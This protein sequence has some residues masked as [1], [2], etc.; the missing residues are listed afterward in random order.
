MLRIAIAILALIV[1]VNLGTVADG[2]NKDLSGGFLASFLTLLAGANRRA[3]LALGG[4]AD[5]VRHGWAL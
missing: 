1:P 4:Y 5:A 3:E 2:V